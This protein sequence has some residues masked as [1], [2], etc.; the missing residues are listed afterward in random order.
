MNC[1]LVDFLV[2]SLTQAKPVSNYLFVGPVTLKFLEKL[3]C[4]LLMDVQC[5]NDAAMKDTLKEETF[6]RRK[7]CTA[8]KF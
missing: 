7:K 2:V 6:T 1:S 5:V 4:N 3:I 8:I